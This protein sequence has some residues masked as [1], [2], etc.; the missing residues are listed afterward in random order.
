MSLSFDKLV[1][2]LAL[3]TAAFVQTPGGTAYN[4]SRARNNRR[5]KETGKSRGFAFLAYE[6]QRSTVLAVD[7]LNGMKLDGRI[8]RVEHVLDYRKKREEVR[9]R[10]LRQVRGHTT[11]DWL[12]VEEG[13]HAR[14]LACRWGTRWAK[15][16][17]QRTN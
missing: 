3:F 6:D 1:G 14:E 15:E 2:K 4:D 17:S 9:R 13:G 12:Q 10:R 5:D 16:R 8:V 7:N 11:G